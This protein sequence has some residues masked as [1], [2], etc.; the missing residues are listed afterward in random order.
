MK[1]LFDN[2]SRQ[3]SKIVTKAYSTSFSMGIKFLA[4][5]FHDPIYGVYG[6]VRLAD[7]I[8][9]SFH[10]YD[11]R[12]LLAEFKV[13]TYKAIEQKISLNPILNSFQEVVNK[14]EIDP[15]TIETFLKS[16]EMDLDKNTYDQNGYEE[17][18]LGSAEVVGLMCLSVFIEGNKEKY[19]ELKPYAMKL[20]SA[21]QKINFLRD[22]K[23]DADALGRLYFPQLRTQ[24]FN[25]VTKEEIES[26]ILKDF[27]MGF[28]GIKKLP[29]D[30]RFGVYVAY[31]YYSQLLA[32]IMDMPASVIMEERV[33]ISDK[34][35]YALFFGSYFRHS[36]NLL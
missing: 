29:K 35:K 25:Q 31:I 15:W 28:E 10:D 11:K 23:A 22:F 17:Y 19:E 34:R 27:K 6:F 5:R 26:D 4:K 24:E 8:V 3:S 14:F 32:K 20:G 13:D 7:E 9:D 30:A 1:I 33:R 18:I 16:M 12:Q 21:F 36:F 2:I